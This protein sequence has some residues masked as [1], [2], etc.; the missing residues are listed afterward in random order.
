LNFSFQNDAFWCTLYSEQRWGP[1]KVA[2]PG[3]AYLP[4]PP[5]RRACIEAYSYCSSRGP[6]RMLCCRS[7]GTARPVVL[8][9][10]DIF[11]AAVRVRCLIADTR[12]AFTRVCLGNIATSLKSDGTYRPISFVIAGVMP[13]N[14]HTCRDTHIQTHT[15]GNSA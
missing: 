4:T 12:C 13:R 5:S 14:K 8:A 10:L 2:G 9:L 7:L 15:Q 3:V 11:F 1:P 6:G